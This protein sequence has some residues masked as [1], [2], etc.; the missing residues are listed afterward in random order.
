MNNFLELHSS[1]DYLNSNRPYHTGTWEYTCVSSDCFVPFQWTTAG[2]DYSIVAVDVNGNET[3]FEAD[4]WDT[5]T[6]ITG[7][8]LTGSGPWDLAGAIFSCS[9]VVAFDYI[10]SNSFSLDAY[11]PIWINFVSPSNLGSPDYWTLAV[12][13]NNVAQYQKVGLDSWN[14]QVYYTPTVS[15]SDYQ[16]RLVCGNTTDQVDLS[17]MAT[18]TS[19]A[20]R[21]G[22]TIWYTGTTITNTVT[23]IFYIKVTDGDTTY[24]SDWCDPCGFTGKLKFKVSCSYDL[25]GLPYSSGFEQWIYK[26]ASVRRSPRSEIEIT[27]ETRNGV[28]IDEKI[29]AAVRYVVKMKCTESEWE[30]FV[31]AMSGTIEIIDATGRTFNCTSAEITDPT[32][33]RSNGVFEFS[34]VDTN[35]ISIY[36]QA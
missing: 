8:T 23:D 32:W 25:G 13:K 36:T 27:A 34:F 22:N 15:G 3:D 33:Y 1:S 7:W 12:L 20:S 18:Q 21:S 11:K 4:L 14:G 26:D 29:V 6:K 5:D 30:A 31:H 17:A 2:S 19:I 24:Y 35:N 16:I 10:T 28:R 9:D